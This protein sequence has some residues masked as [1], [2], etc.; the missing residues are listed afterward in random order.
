MTDEIR[1]KGSAGMQE[2]Q[3]LRV[4]ATKLKALAE[5]LEI[6][7]ISA[8][9]LNGESNDM[10]Y[11]DQRSIEGAKS[12]ANKIDLVNGEIINLS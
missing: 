5:R 9:Q 8:T 3:I 2:Y 12:I 10:K 4:F 1:K 6:T 7:I 11:K